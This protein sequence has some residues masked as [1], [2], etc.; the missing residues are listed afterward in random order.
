M[1]KKC[2]ITLYFLAHIN[3]FLL[4]ALAIH[5]LIYL[6]LKSNQRESADV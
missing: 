2:L 6:K 1:G 3:T 5:T 4:Q